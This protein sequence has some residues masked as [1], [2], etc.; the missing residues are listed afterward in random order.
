[1]V[2]FKDLSERVERVLADIQ[3][4]QSAERE[5]LDQL[6]S[7]A[8]TSAA[9]AQLTRKIAEV[10]QLR[11]DAY[12][13]LEA[14]FEAHG[15]QTSAARA[16][17]GQQMKIAKMVDAELAAARRRLAVLE[18]TREQKSR[19]AEINTYYASYYDGYRTLMQIVVATCAPMIVLGLLAQRGLLSGGVYGVL[20]GLALAIGG[21]AVFRQ[22]MF[23][24]T[25]DPNQWDV[26][27][28]SRHSG[29]SKKPGPGS[30]ADKSASKTTAAAAAP[31]APDAAAATICTGEACCDSTSAYDA[32]S[33]KC[34]ELSTS[35]AR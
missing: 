14:V 30:G 27:A 25:R 13:Q 6:E 23:L 21:L 12:A 2:S 4:L 20:A 33:N 11:G 32:A 34:V 22:T 8:T 31:D 9:R 19:S 5:S 29:S 18:T 1:M 28:I 24:S 15:E 17:V 7:D 35:A 10:H 16:A 3:Q 26:S